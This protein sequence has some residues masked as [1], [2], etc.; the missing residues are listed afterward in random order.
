MGNRKPRVIHRTSITSSASSLPMFHQFTLL[1]V[2]RLDFILYT[3]Q[4]FSVVYELDTAVF[5][6]LGLTHIN[7]S[8]PNSN[9]IANRHQF[10]WRQGQDIE[11][12]ALLT[13]GPEEQ[14]SLAISCRTRSPHSARILFYQ[15]CTSPLSA[16]LCWEGYCHRMW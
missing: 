11:K 12:L 10:C 8:H 3:V 13:L 15:S 14:K 16:Q 2:G 9:G 6:N 7:T 1:K 5:I 4:R